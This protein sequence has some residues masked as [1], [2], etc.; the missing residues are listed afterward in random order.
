MKIGLYGYENAGSTTLFNALTGREIPTGFSS[1]KKLNIGTVKVPDKRI[2]ILSG[3][4]KPKKTI[5]SELIFSDF[6]AAGKNSVRGKALA[7]V[8]EARAVDIL[9]LVVGSFPNQFDDSDPDPVNELSNLLTEMVILDLDQVENFIR[10][11]K[12]VKGTAQ[13]PFINSAVVKMKPHLEEGKS[14]RTLEL[15]KEE[16]Q[17][18]TGFSFLS[19]KPALVAVNVDENKITESISQ[20]MIELC[21]EHKLESFILS[22]KVEEEIAKLSSEDQDMFMEDLGITDL[23]GSRFIRKAYELANL[24]SFFTVG[25]DEVRSWTIRKGTFAKKAAGTIHSDL[26]KGF[27]RAEV[28]HYNDIIE[29]DGNEAQLKKLGKHRLEGKEYIVKDG[30]ILNIRFNV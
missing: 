4:Y 28:F 24:H 26:E 12:K 27:I 11:Q 25:P 8:S 10:R 15:K 14:L 7:N 2:D 1:E 5:Y 19:L 29:V 18:I 13:N 30:D 20:E 3:L 23:I 22:A 16:L 21:K 17:H 9:A 6:P